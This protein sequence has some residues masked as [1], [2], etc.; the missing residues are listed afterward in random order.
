MA[1]RL[2]RG[3]PDGT[4]HQ[5]ADLYWQA[6]GRK[7]GPALGPAHRGRAFLAAHL[8]RDRGITAIGDDGQI[9]GIAGYHLAGR[10][11]AGGSARDVV[12]DYGLFSGCGR[13]AVLALLSRKQQEDVLLMDGICV[14]AQHRGSGIGSLLLNEIAAVAAENS[15]SHIRLDVVDVNPRAR[16]L[17]QRHGFTALRT[18]HTPFLRALMGFGAVTTMQQKVGQ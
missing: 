9:L 12:S 14:A 4:E 15:C 16:A 3:I 5:V 18:Q 11:L 6:F 1:P 13:L 2:Q 10:S 17:Y 7:L 8:N